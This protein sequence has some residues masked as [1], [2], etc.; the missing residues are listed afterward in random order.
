MKG[1]TTVFHPR[2]Q[3]D[4]GFTSDVGVDLKAESS[5]QFAPFNVNVLHLA[6]RITMTC[7]QDISYT[8]KTMVGGVGCS[9]RSNP[10]LFTS[11]YLSEPYGGARHSLSGSRL[12]VKEYR[13]VTVPSHC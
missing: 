9:V 5:E 6:V 12:G 8:T 11:Y 4:C 10:A 3:L 7:L 1:L 13:S 2:G